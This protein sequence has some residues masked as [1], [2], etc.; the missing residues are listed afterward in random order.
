MVTISL[1]GPFS[2]CTGDKKLLMLSSQ[3]QFVFVAALFLFLQEGCSGRL[4]QLLLGSL[5]RV[6]EMNLKSVL[7]WA[8]CIAPRPA[9][10]IFTLLAD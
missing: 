1:A 8:Q 2:L 5:D 7:L 9:V 10:Y 3:T 4:F 6:Q